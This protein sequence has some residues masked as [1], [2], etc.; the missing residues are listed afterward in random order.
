MPT[1]P[2]EKFSMT[3]VELAFSQIPLRFFDARGGVDSQTGRTFSRLDAFR[4]LSRRLRGYEDEP[5]EDIRD[6]RSSSS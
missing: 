3:A 1:D 4:V 2:G 5:E 6:S